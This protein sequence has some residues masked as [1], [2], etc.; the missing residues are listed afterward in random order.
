MQNLPYI[1]LKP[2]EET[3]IISGHPW[4]FDN[5]IAAIPEDAEDGWLVLV[6]NSAG[7][8]IGV[9]YLNQKSKITVRM[10]DTLKEPAAVYLNYAAI[11]ELLKD[12][13]SKACAKREKITNSDAK[14]LIFSEVDSLPGLIVDSYKE[15]LVIQI[16]TLGME[17]LK[18]T[19]V[20]ILDDMLEPK[21]I[22]EKS[23]S[24]SRRK[25]G[26]E[27]VHGELKGKVKPVKITEN[28]LKFNVDIEK[29]SKTGFYL[30]QRDN[31]DRLKDYVKGK[32][33]LDAFCYTGGF[34]VYALHYGASEV[35]G[36][37]S[38]EEA[39]ETADKNVK[40]NKLK[41]AQFIKSDVFE[42]IRQAGR[43]GKKYDVI[44]LD[45]PAFSTGKKV[46]AGGMQGYRDLHYHA[47]KL[48][49]DGGVLFTFS[50]SQNVAMKDLIESVKETSRGVKCR[51]EILGQMFQAKDHPYNTAIPE[52]FYLKG[53]IVK[54][55]A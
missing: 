39:L 25:E 37:D 38:S 29:G 3:R 51:V 2:G 40:L 13:I 34:T 4:I 23:V 9:G 54:K 12:K 15:T 48:L 49:N 16:N 26:L 33:V 55:K 45:P 6:K 44:I 42:F 35:T 17:K 52:T 36:V 53:V 19:I 22:Y 18:D 47:L 32:S 30:D 20:K 21:V 28:T 27:A 41:G 5:E 24:R 11:E 46:K 50:C 14:R 7:L 10:L 43:D 31:R 1:I 8:Y